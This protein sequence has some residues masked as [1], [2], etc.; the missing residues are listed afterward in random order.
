LPNAQNLTN[1]CASDRHPAA[2][3]VFLDPD[4]PLHSLEQEVC[5][6][7][8]PQVRTFS[9]R[10][11]GCRIPIRIGVERGDYPESDR[12]REEGWIAERLAKLYQPGERHEQILADGRCILI[13]ERLTE[14]GSHRLR[15]DIT[16]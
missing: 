11:R 15:V 8:Q 16:D 1:G 13:E 5:R 12:P 3:I 7:L 14:D 2:G 10:T 6:D 9:S 4:G